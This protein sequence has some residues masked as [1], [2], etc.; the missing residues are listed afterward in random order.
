MRSTL[1]VS[2]VLNEKVLQFNSHDET[3]KSETLL[4]AVLSRFF[5]LGKSLIL[6]R[7]PLNLLKKKCYSVSTENTLLKLCFAKEKNLQFQE[8]VDIFIDKK[9]L[10]L[11]FQEIGDIFIDKKD[12][13]LLFVISLS[14][15]VTLFIGYL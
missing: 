12:L 10:C 8:I 7:T 2:T 15:H 6:E 5:S 3:K 14:F 4:R 9:D 1:S 11:L 13:C